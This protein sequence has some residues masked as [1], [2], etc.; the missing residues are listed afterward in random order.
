VI[1][2]LAAASQRRSTAVLVAAAVVA[3]AGLALAWR[4]KAPLGWAPLVLV[5]VTVAWLR[6]PGAIAVALG[7]A[8]TVFGL[9]LG[10]AASIGA[11]VDVVVASVLAAVAVG[12]ALA[13]AQ[14]PADDRVR[15][16]VASAVV[17]LGVGFAVL[18]LGPDPWRDLGRVGIV[19]AT[20]CYLSLYTVAPAIEARRDQSR[21]SDAR[22]AH[23]WLRW[24]PTTFWLV[25]L[26]L[27]WLAFAP[28]IGLG[29]PTPMLAVVA[30]G[31]VA[32]VAWRAGSRL[33]TALAVVSLAI[34]L[35][36]L[37]G[38]TSRLDIRLEWPVVTLTTGVAAAGALVVASCR[39]PN[40]LLL[41]ARRGAAI[42]GA[43]AVALLVAWLSSAAAT[44]LSVGAGLGLAATA[45]LLPAW[46]ALGQVEAPALPAGA[47][48]RRRWA[49][50]G[51][52]VG[53]AGLAPIAPGTMGALA[54]LPLAPLFALM[55]PLLRVAVLV[56]LTLGG[57]WA[58]KVY[59]EH[60]PRDDPQEIVVDELAGCAI[61][62]AVVPHDPFWVAVGFG[63][64]RYLDIVKPWPVAWLGDRHGAFGVMAD[65]IAAG[66]IGAILIA[67]MQLV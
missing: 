61:A 31:A 46:L 55:P 11:H 36:A 54:A 52:T 56:A 5:F 67:A 47:P 63:L 13:L 37:G 45:L 51:A 19:A 28:A 25:V 14:Q 16:D 38:A 65:D 22:A 18:A 8:V 59:M 29:A 58:S 1:A 35:M 43:F 34:T 21:G 3:V 9:S 50:H 41:A 7:P 44:S 12:P 42:P 20:V 10:I 62:I 33:G 57:W 39:D 27:T 15:G 6:H 24:S 66:I 30:L 53:L 2:R 48:P 23:A 17:V 26:A 64:F 49:I 32:L 60:D 4:G 40:Q